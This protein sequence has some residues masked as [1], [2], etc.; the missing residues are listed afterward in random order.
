MG[1]SSIPVYYCNYNNP[2]RIVYPYGEGHPLSTVST[3]QARQDL[4]GEKAFLSDQMRQLNSIPTN[5][6]YRQAFV[7][8]ALNLLSSQAAFLNAS[9]T[10]SLCL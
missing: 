8:R 6:S 3:F 2:N 9:Q 10:P 1:F 4:K 7:H 5:K